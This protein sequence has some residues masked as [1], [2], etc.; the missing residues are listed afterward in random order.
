MARTP[1][2]LPEEAAAHFRSRLAFETD[3]SDLAADLAAGVG[4][5]VIVD[6]RTSAAFAESHIVG[7][8]SL[9]HAT[10][11][12]RTTA[13][14][15]RGDLHVTYCWGPACNASTRAAA[16]LASLGFSVK[17]LVGGLSAWQFEGFAVEGRST[18]CGC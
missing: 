18:I 17:E 10:I 16:A 9:P 15:G 7:A 4:G 6:A 11:D 5:L 2:A 12:A 14:L 13:H 1:A 3:P 8:I